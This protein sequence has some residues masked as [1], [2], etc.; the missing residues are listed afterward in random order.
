MLHVLWKEKT[1]HHY[2]LNNCQVFS[3]YS[4]KRSAHGT[5]VWKTQEQTKL[6]RPRRKWVVSI[7]MY[8]KYRII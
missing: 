8:L 1:L 6:A 2:L 3:K 5:Y 4:P 7:K